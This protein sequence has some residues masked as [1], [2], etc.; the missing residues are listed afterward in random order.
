MIEFESQKGTS[1]HFNPQIEIYEGRE[2]EKIHHRHIIIKGTT[3]TR[4]RRQDRPFY[5]N[6]DDPQI[7]EK[8]ENP[9]IS[10]AEKAKEKV[11]E[12]RRKKGSRAS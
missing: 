4:S 10:D 9:I 1:H 6:D 8:R 3:N 12:Y 7:R 2:T 11:K 5:A